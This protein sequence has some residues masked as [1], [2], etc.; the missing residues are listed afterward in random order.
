LHLI[1][2]IS[3][4]WGGGP[5]SDIEFTMETEVMNSPFLRR[6]HKRETL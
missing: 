1:E 6:T 5:F 3:F 2:A 4:Y